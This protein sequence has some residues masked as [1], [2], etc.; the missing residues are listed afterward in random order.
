MFDV[1]KIRVQGGR[2]G[3]GA[4]TFRREKYVPYGGPDGG[5]GGDGGAVVLIADQSVATFKEFIRGGLYRAK[6]GE[7]GKGQKKVGKRGDELLIRVPV[8]L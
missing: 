5:D 8:G 4:I 2:G 6:D 7:D 1:V 3:K